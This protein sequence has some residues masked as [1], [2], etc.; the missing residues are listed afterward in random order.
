MD[1]FSSPQFEPVKAALLEFLDTVKNSA[2]SDPED[3]RSIIDQLQLQT[4]VLQGQLNNE[5]A[6]ASIGALAITKNEN[7]LV[8]VSEQQSEIQHYSD[9]SMKLLDIISKRDEDYR[10][11]EAKNEH[12]RTEYGTKINLLNASVKD[13]KASFKSLESEKKKMERELTAARNELMELK[14]TLA[15]VETVKN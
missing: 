11:L 7:L 1:I 5:Q 10:L 14:I 15:K 3:L 2:Q 12:L 4:T 6:R 9:Q 8:R 13:H